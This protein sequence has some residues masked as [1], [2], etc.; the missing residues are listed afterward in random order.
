[1]INENIKNEIKNLFTRVEK[2]GF[3]ISNIT[4]KINSF[5]DVIMRLKRDDTKHFHTL[6]I[7]KDGGIHSGAFGKDFKDIE[8][9]L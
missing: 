2:K 1:M 6:T 3:T 7:F 8:I 4:Y 9:S 5:G